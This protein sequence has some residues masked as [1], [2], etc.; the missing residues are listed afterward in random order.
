VSFAVLEGFIEGVAGD[1]WGSLG[2]FGRL[3][4]IF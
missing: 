4:E 1:L 3:D 2:V